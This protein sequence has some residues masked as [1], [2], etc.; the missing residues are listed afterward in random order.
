MLQKKNVTKLLSTITLSS[1]LLLSATV[2]AGNEQANVVEASTSSVKLTHN[3]YVY[4]YQGKRIK[5]ARTLK[6]GRSVKAYRTKTIHGKK[7]LYIGNHRYINLANTKKTSA[8]KALFKVEVV[9]P[10]PAYKLPNKHITKTFVDGTVNVYAE[11]KDSR[12]K[13]WYKVGT[14]K[15]INSELTRKLTEKS[16]QEATSATR[17]NE[18]VSENSHTQEQ[19]SNKHL[20]TEHTQATTSNNS[21]K[22]NEEQTN[23]SNS[24]SEYNFSNIVT[25]A[26]A[27]QVEK[28]FVKY[29]NIERTNRGLTPVTID[30]S[31]QTGMET[32]SQELLTNFTHTR[33]NG[34]Y[35]HYNEAIAEN[36]AT[37]TSTPSSVAKAVVDDLIYHDADSNWGH[38]GTLLNSSY[39]KIGVGITW[40][41]KPGCSW[42]NY[43]YPNYYGFTFATAL[44]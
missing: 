31:L 18:K 33:P 25:T 1:A 15:W 12:G 29:L 35:T 36:F 16:D 38:R 14:N 22:Q 13:T 30:S 39:T 23:N 10:S 4:N 24:S 43:A 44:D 11:K 3:A 21:S 34:Q 37:T 9:Y 7:Y 28:E 19:A 6:K 42:M 8:N 17:S 40:E 2:V 20:N 27:H 26:F 41:P 5:G 32:R